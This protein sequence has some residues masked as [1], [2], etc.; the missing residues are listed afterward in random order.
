M[1]LFDKRGSVGKLLQTR[2]DLEKEY[3][4]NVF[5]AVEAAGLHQAPFAFWTAL[6]YCEQH[7]NR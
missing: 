7:R 5:P 4:A 3:A 1:S 2:H 6:L